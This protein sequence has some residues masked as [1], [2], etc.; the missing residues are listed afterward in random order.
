MEQWSIGE[1]KRLKVW[2][3][4]LLRTIHLKADLIPSNAPFQYSNIT[5]FHYSTAK[6]ISSGPNDL[7]L[8]V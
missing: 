4:F 5:I 7:V 3:Y 1:Q 8:N 6:P 2:F